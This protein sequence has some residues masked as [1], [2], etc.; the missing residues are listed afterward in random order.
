[1]IDL[2]F[3]GSVEVNKEKGKTKTNFSNFLNIPFLLS[4]TCYCLLCQDEVAEPRKGG[5]WEMRW[6]YRV[7]LW[8]GSADT[9]RLHDGL[10]LYPKSSG[11]LY[12]NVL[13]TVPTS[14]T[15]ETPKKPM[16]QQ[17]KLW[18]SHTME[19]KLVKTSLLYPHATVRVNLSKIL[20][21]EKG[22]SQKITH[23][24]IKFS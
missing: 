2:G 16:H 10:C 21:N 1:M 5:R 13:S 23:R 9:W 3:V 24:M 14:K 12:K 15:L 11:K 19:Y 22:K 8:P 17:N 7:W 18:H 6:K 4:S 20:L